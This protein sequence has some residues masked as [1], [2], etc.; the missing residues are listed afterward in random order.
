[1]TIDEDRNKDKFENDSFALFESYRF[2]TT[3]R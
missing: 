1:M 2:V 3:E